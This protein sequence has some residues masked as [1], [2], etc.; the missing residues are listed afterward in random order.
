MKLLYTQSEINSKV[1]L[2]AKKLNKIDA[3]DIVVVCVL[4]GAFIFFS[5]L[6]KRI[7][8]DCETA[9]IQCKSYNDNRQTNLKVDFLGNGFED[10]TVIL[11]EDIVDTGKTLDKLI[12]EIKKQK[13]NEVF[14][15]SLL[16]KNNTE[17][18]VDY[19]GFIVPDNK[20]V[21]GYGMDNNQKERNLI[22]IYEL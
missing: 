3:E 14:I 8:L 7:K 9:F 10:K 12:E 18:M 4:N 2:I 6:M 17:R 15:V 1:N 20:F 5:D 19:Y 11:I 21:Y 16:V 13:P 22:N